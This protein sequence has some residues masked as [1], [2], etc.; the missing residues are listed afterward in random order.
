M[1]ARFSGR[2]VRQV[3]LVNRRSLATLEGHPHVV[4]QFALQVEPFNNQSF[5][6]SMYFLMVDQ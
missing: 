5:R 2:A 6:D 4:R 1:L 3:N